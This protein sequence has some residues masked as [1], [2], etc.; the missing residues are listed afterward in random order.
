MTN[1]EVT[2]EYMIDK[3]I[4]NRELLKEGE[5]HRYNKKQLMALKASDVVWL[6]IQGM[7]LSMKLND[8]EIDYCLD[9]YK[10]NERLKGRILSKVY[11]YNFNDQRVNKEL[12]NKKSLHSMLEFVIC[13]DYIKGINTLLKD[14]NLKERLNNIINKELKNDTPQQA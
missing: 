12:D 4:N 13:F 9:I 11:N 10:D 2:K 3:Y 14:H 5:E 6:C 1:K 7:S 8:N